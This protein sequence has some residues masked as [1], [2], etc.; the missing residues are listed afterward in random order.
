MDKDRKFT[1][2][3]VL[4]QIL[5]LI[6]VTLIRDAAYKHNSNRYY[7]KLPLRVHLV[8]LLYGVFSYCNGLRELCEGLL[9]CEGKLSHLGFDKAPARSTLSDANGSRSYLVFATIYQHLLEKYHGVISDSRLKGLSISNLKIIDSSTISLFGDILRGVGRPRLDGARRKGGIKVHAMM[10]AFSGVT[11]F[12][13]MTPA[14][15]H[16]RQFLLKLKLP[17]ESF[18]VFDKAYNDYRQFHLWSKQQVWFVSRM[19][20]NAVYHVCK[21]LTDKTRKQKNKGV[22]KDQLITVGYKQEK[23]VIRLRLRRV[24]YKAEDGRIY[25]FI[26]NNLKISAGQVARIYKYRWMI[27]LLFKQ[28]KQNFP[29]RYFWGDSQNAIKIQIYC[30]LIAQLLMVVLRKKSAT[31]KSFANMI[32]V[33]RLHLMSYVELLSFIKDTYLAWRRVNNPVLSSA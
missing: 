4:S 30:V 13:R 25:V 31:K 17:K 26:T 12:V 3:P 8:S 33:I 5:S 29:L 2:Q 27:E 18:I 28:I 10:D 1:G 14:K 9:A 20:E 6:P 24:T 23:D 7:K 22:L 11:E 21:V 15:V 16:D 19:K 32:T